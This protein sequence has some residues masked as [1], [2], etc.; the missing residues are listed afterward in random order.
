MTIAGQRQEAGR[1]VI[2][3]RGSFD[4]MEAHR[5]LD[6][7]GRL[8]LSAR[9]SVDFRETR[10]VDDFAFAMLAGPI[11]AGDGPYF[12]LV[13]LSRHLHRLLRH[14]DSSPPPY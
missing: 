8:P 5:L 2:I 1:T 12:Q 6:I 11:V 7:V 13:G 3:L 14:M 4:A 9:V 10:L